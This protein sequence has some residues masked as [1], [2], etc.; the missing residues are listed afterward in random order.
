[1][2]RK[3]TAVVLCEDLQS[4]CLLYRYLKQRGFERI[5]VLPL[6]AACGEQYVR[7]HYAEQVKIQRRASVAQVL[8]VQIDAD[9]GTMAEHHRQLAEELEK[10]QEGPRTSNEL[11][12]L[13]VPRWE[14]ET[15]LHHYRGFEG[16]VETEQYPKFKG[17]EAEA[18]IPA[19]RALVELVDGR[20][21]PPPN[22]PSLTVTRDE[23]RRLP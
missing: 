16:V 6:P 19:V 22:I 7:K 14:T 13:I 20:S 1:M 23:L 4:R 18:A 10:A 15:W 9:N 2:S 8:V 11:I 21:E 17:W 12:A 5:R 3:V